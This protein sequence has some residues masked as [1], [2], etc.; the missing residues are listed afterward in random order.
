MKNL[1]LNLITVNINE[2]LTADAILDTLWIQTRGEVPGNMDAME[3][4]SV[5]SRIPEEN[6]VH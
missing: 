1:I 4:L 6:E 3:E 5:K 2:R